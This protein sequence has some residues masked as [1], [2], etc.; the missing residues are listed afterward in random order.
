[1]SNCYVSPKLVFLFNDVVEAIYE[2]KELIKE[3]VEE[4]PKDVITRWIISHEVERDGDYSK[5]EFYMV[6]LTKK[7]VFV[8]EGFAEWFE[9]GEQ[10]DTIKEYTK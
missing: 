10:E 2:G 8:K 7:G 4:A 6:E 9:D 5:D 3:E 1:M